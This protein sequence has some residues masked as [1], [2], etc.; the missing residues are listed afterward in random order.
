MRTTEEMYALAAKYRGNIINEMTW[1]EKFVD[2]YITNYFTSDE[3]KVVD[4]HLLFLGDNRI[5]F[6]AKRQIFIHLAMKYD[7]LWYNEYKSFRVHPEP[8]KFY[9]MNND[10]DY[11]TQQRNI[12]AHRIVDTTEDGRLDNEKI[13]F[14]S[15]KNEAKTIPFSEETYI[16]MMFTI[17]DLTKYL[18]KR[19]N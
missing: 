6:D 9:S 10:L 11:L 8:K 14:L 2:S 15:F 16:E 12:L 19:V 18:V 7:L 17:R 1:M 4:M 13:S 5:S 3:T